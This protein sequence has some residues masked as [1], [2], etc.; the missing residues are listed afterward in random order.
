MKTKRCKD[1]IDM[2]PHMPESEEKE[3]DEDLTIG[4]F[5]GLILDTY[6]K[7]DLVKS[8]KIVVKRDKSISTIKFGI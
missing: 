6:K 5:V 4:A 8:Y 2:F 7:S 3:K 1:T